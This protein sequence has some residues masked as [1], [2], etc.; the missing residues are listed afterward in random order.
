MKQI[1]LTLL[2]SFLTV[3]TQAFDT[4]WIPENVHDE[5]QLMES[6]VFVSNEEQ[7][8]LEANAYGEAIGATNALV[9][10]TK[11]TPDGWQYDVTYYKCPESCF[12][13]GASNENG[14]VGKEN[15]L[16]IIGY[17]PI[18]CS[19]N[20]V[21]PQLLEFDFDGDGF[22]GYAIRYKTIYGG[23]QGSR[24]ELTWEVAFIK[25]TNGI[26]SKLDIELPSFETEVE[27]SYFHEIIVKPNSLTIQFYILGS[28]FGHAVIDESYHLGSNVLSPSS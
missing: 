17:E 6:N 5:C 13:S 10:S 8:N 25:N 11:S 22:N 16:T 19:A 27:E 9:D 26:L 23:F 3:H 21:V 18:D 20:L 4:S 15:L 1:S 28:S 24:G 7:W 2:L 12:K 14:M